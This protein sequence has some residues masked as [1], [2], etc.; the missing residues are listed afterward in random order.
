MSERKALCGAGCR[1]DICSRLCPERV[2]AWRA[3]TP[4]PVNRQAGCPNIDSDPPVKN[5]PSRSHIDQLW[6]RAMD[7]AIRMNE[8]YTRYRFYELVR[9]EVLAEVQR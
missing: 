9:E 4:A 7:E 5:F 8:F 3:A 2:A 6:H 1:E